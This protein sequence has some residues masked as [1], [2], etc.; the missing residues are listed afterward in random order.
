M[1]KADAYEIVSK[2]PIDNWVFGRTL[3]ASRWCD[4]VARGPMGIADPMAIPRLQAD[5]TVRVEVT[6][7]ASETPRHLIILYAA[8]FMVRHWQSRHIS[9]TTVLLPSED[10]GVIGSVRIRDEHIRQAFLTVADTPGDE[11][12]ELYGDFP[13][14]DPQQDPPLVY[15]ASWGDDR[16]AL[17]VAGLAAQQAIRESTA[18][19]K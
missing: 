17:T 15:G 14:I 1:P 4:T 11:H 2:R 16:L 19:P 12:A 3:T 9:E 8:H 5:G 7:Q 6:D 10:R 13:E 18:V